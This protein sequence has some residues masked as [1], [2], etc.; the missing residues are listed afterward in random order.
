MD[1]I[2]H[3]TQGYLIGYLTT[4]E[5]IIGAVSG[6][7]GALPDI[8]GEY[9]GRIRGDYYRMYDRLHSGDINETMQY[10]PPWGLH[11]ILDRITHGEGKRWYCGKWWEYFCP[12]RWKERMWIETAGWVI[13]ILIILGIAIWKR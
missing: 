6:L 12:W 13:N 7:I 4:G 5:P 10:L 11:T 1:V 8:I 3:T 9:Y 2:S